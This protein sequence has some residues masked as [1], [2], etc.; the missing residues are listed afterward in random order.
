MA[1]AN[2][3]ADGAQ[4]Q[5]VGV[6]IERLST[7]EAHMDSLVARVDGEL[8]RRDV[9]GRPRGGRRRRGVAK[10]HMRILSIVRYARAQR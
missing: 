5:F 3:Q 9:Q 6:V 8:A 7:L 1:T 10:M 2:K 4:R